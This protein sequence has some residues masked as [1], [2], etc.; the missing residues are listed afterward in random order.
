MKLFF[1]NSVHSAMIIYIYIYIIFLALGKIIV[2]EIKRL[3]CYIIGHDE[4]II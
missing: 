3:A 1:F 2:L 4:N